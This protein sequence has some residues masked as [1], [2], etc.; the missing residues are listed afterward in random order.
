MTEQA[1]LPRVF[2]DF[3]NCDRQGRVRLS[4]I[5]TVQD[6]NR[7]GVVLREG[8]ELL[9]YSYEDETDGVATY[10]TEEG[11]WVAKFDWNKFRD[12]PGDK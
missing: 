9:L 6:L 3:H 11:R 10:S 12:L 8:T 5:G 1:Q 4:A 2:V 7:L